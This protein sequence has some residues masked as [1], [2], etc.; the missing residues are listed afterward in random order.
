MKALVYAVIAAVVVIGGV[1]LWPGSHVGP[2]P[3][4]HGRDACARCRMPITRPGYAGELRD[5]T[6]TL[7]KY[8]DVG[9]L[10]RAMVAMRDVVPEAWVEDHRTFE[11][12]PLLG[13]TLARARAGETPMGSG[14]VAF[15]NAED[16]AAFVRDGGGELVTLETLLREPV[17]YADADARNRGETEDVTTVNP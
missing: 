3:I 7:T 11:L 2:E 17:R 13:A 5:R 14:I 10:L 15:A 4:A 1:V 9:C 8:D 16:A 12:V 6:G